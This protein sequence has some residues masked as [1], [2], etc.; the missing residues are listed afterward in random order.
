MYWEC[1]A[2][3]LLS[4]FLNLYISS[5]YTQS[6]SVIVNKAKG[7]N[8]FSAYEHKTVIVRNKKVTAFMAIRGSNK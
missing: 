6:Y 7:E 2:R 8:Q 5:Y 3:R 1:Y 4:I